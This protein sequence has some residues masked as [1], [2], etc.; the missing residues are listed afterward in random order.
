[1]LTEIIYNIILTKYCRN[2]RLAQINWSSTS[3]IC[4]K[5]Y[6]NVI[7][8]TMAYQITSP[9]I[10]YSTVYSGA[11][12]R[13][14]QSSASLAFVR[15]I[16]RWPVNSPHK[17]P[18]T[19]TNASIWWRHHDVFRRYNIPRKI[20]TMKSTQIWRQNE[21]W[22]VPNSVTLIKPIV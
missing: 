18:V 8:T 1:M 3:N 7:M 21:M 22:R 13:K 10:V 2:L 16:H 20:G 6:S 17:G 19:R 12:Q 5:H 9:T 4:R 14:H 11:D 15:G